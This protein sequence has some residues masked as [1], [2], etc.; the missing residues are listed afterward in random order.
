MTH[1][2]DRRKF[3]KITALSV[4]HAFAMAL[5]TFSVGRLAKIYA[6]IVNRYAIAFARE[7]Y[8]I[9]R[10]GAELLAAWRV[11]F[12]YYAAGVTQAWSKHEDRRF[13]CR[14]V[15]L[16]QGSCFSGVSRGV[17]FKRRKMVS[18]TFLTKLPEDQ[19]ALW[20]T[21][22]SSHSWGTLR[23]FLLRNKRKHIFYRASKNS[24]I[25]IECWYRGY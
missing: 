19:N 20:W 21:Y 1:W 18:K 12:F 9:M 15:S 14:D 3:S 11:Q 7:A 2:C 25:L 10:T 24:I 23:Y 5:V 6:H 17:E 22:R 8:R 4:S 16:A 13:F